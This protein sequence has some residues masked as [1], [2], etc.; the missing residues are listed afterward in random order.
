MK[1]AILSGQLFWSA[2]HA[3]TFKFCTIG[4][5]LLVLSSADDLMIWVVYAR[6]KHEWK[7]YLELEYY[8]PAAKCVSSIYDVRFT[9]EWVPG[10]NLEV[11]DCILL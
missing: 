3:K 7:T 11:S 1:E 4:N 9:S 6:I 2:K 10:A 8:Q 5:K